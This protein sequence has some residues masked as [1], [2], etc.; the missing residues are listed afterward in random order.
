MKVQTRL[1]PN[2]GTL[3]YPQESIANK[4][5]RHRQGTA[6]SD[7]F[8]RINPVPTAQVTSPVVEKVR[9]LIGR[10]PLPLK[11]Q[12]H[13]LISRIEA[14]E[15]GRLLRK[16]ENAL[17][18]EI[19]K[20]NT[21]FPEPTELKVGL[22]QYSP[23]LDNTS[24]V[25]QGEVLSQMLTDL[26]RFFQK[27]KLLQDLRDGV[28]DTP[29]KAGVMTLAESEQALKDEIEA[30]IKAGLYLIDTY[31]KVEPTRS[32]QKIATYPKAAKRTKQVIPRAKIVDPKLPLLL[33]EQGSPIKHFVYPINL[34]ALERPRK[35]SLA[36]L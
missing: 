25:E 35:P 20:L 16:F 27:R 18:R 6:F 32:R 3:Q 13:D 2:Q 8:R 36:H 14:L 34:K 21:L 1:S 24:L 17:D 23:T 11:A 19:A 22:D 5:S 4:P 29:S 15:S 31:R 7:L 28:E 9:G 26:N 30:Q 10:S 12:W 33:G